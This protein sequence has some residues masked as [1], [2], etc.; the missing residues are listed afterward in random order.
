MRKVIGKNIPILITGE[1]GTGKELLAQRDSQRF[2][3]PRR[4]FVAVN[5]ASIPETLIEAELFG[6]E[7][8]AFTGARRNGAAGKLVQANGGTLFLDEI[9]DM[10]LPLQSAPAA[11]AAGARRDPLGRTQSIPVDVAII[12]A[13]HRNLREMIAQD[14]FA[15]TCTTASTDS[16]SSCRRC[17]SAPTCGGD[18]EDAALR[19]RRRRRRHAPVHRRRRR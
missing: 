2:A 11:R 6:Y 3:A 18:H 1:T 13:T 5:C 10:P 9:G 19:E 12:C 15:K 16:S 8:G 4:A 17:A 7:D 14:A